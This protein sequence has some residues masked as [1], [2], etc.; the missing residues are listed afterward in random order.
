MHPP[1]ASVR[2]GHCPLVFLI[3]PRLAGAKNRLHVDL[4]LDSWY[5]DKIKDLKTDTGFETDQAFC[6]WLIET[7]VQVL[8]NE[9]KPGNPKLS[10]MRSRVEQ[11]FAAIP[12]A[13]GACGI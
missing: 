9:R 6:R 5:G 8:A 3:M 2:P 11:A 4:R 12:E 7:T 1:R 13:P 10:D